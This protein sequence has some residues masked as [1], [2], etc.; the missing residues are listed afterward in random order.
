MLIKKINLLVHF[1]V[2]THKKENFAP[3]TVQRYISYFF[4]SAYKFNLD[5]P[6]VLVFDMSDT[7]YANLVFKKNNYDLLFLDSI[8]FLI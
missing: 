2:K 7:G 3:K 6:I 5:D 8:F 4:E 1:V